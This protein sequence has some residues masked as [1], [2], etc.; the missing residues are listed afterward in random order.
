MLE[1]VERTNGA[2]RSEEQIHAG[3][4]RDSEVSK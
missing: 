1:L 2:I 4:E 3:L